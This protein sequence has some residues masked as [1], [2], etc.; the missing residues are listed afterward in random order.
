MSR[1][2]QIEKAQARIARDDAEARL[3]KPPALPAIKPEDDADLQAAFAKVAAGELATAFRTRNGS[4][5]T[6]RAPGGE[7]ITQRWLGLFE[8]FP[9]LSKWSLCRG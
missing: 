9:G 6:T 1:K 4:L 7:L 2:E 8:Q 3:V 5:V